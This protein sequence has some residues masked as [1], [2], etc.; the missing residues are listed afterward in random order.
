MSDSLHESVRIRSFSGPY[1]PAI[2][3]N[4][5]QKN[6]EYGHFLRSFFTLFS[7][8]DTFSIVGAKLF[9]WIYSQTTNPV[10]IYLFKTFDKNRSKRY[11]TCLKLTMET[12][13]QVTG[14]F[15]LY[16]LTLNIFQIL[17]PFGVSIVDFEQVNDNSIIVR[18]SMD[19]HQLRS[20]IKRK[21]FSLDWIM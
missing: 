16:L 14:V 20:Q 8:S 4:A 2:E 19:Y 1:F 3:L 11:K 13:E 6:F 10:G 15:L 5:N 7:N 18:L 9:C 12:P 21:Y 17:L